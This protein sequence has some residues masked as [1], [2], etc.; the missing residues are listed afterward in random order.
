MAEETPQIENEQ[1]SNHTDEGAGASRDPVDE[2]IVDG[3]VFAMLERGVAALERIAAATELAATA[4]QYTSPRAQAEQTE[5]LERLGRLERRL[6]LDRP[7]VGWMSRVDGRLNAL[8]GS[9]DPA[10]K[11]AKFQPDPPTG[12]TLA[13]SALAHAEALTRPPPAPAAAVGER[14]PKGFTPDGN[15]FY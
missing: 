4:P 5:L 6:E 14:V 1:T 15:P 13:T 9:S 12:N 8:E 11:A 10:D 7:V 3:R 2:V